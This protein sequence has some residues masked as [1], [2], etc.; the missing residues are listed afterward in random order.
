MGR[1]DRASL[2]PASTPPFKVSRRDRIATAGY[3]FAQH[4]ALSLQK[5]GFEH[6]VVE[7]GFPGA[8]PDLLRRFGYGIYSARYGNINTAR[9]LL[10][11]FDRA[12][13]VFL[14]KEPAWFEQGRWI[15]P[16]RPFIQPQGFASLDEL[17]RDRSQHFAAVRKMFETLQVF[18]FTL[19]LRSPNGAEDCRGRT[20]SH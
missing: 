13:G 15:D 11:L 17:E 2:N 20:R 18:I 6:L 7:R 9:Q 8:D 5:A 14:P 4:I 10:Q 1:V 12:Y 3:C 19:G 16:F